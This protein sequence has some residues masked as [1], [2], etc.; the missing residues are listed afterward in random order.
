MWN[1]NIKK[2]PLYRVIQVN[3]V[4]WEQS[5]QRWVPSLLLYFVKDSIENTEV[6]FE[7]IQYSARAQAFALF[8]FFIQQ[9]SPSYLP[10]YLSNLLLSYCSSSSSPRPAN[11]QQ[12][13]GT[14]SPGL[15]I[16][17]FCVSKAWLCSLGTKQT[18]T[19][20]DSLDLRKGNFCFLLQN[21]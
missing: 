3:S 7:N 11:M 10:S 4:F 16:W 14:R 2:F 6:R 18:E 12:V 20:T 15:G 17:T 19:W 21:T 13:P 9:S 1:E 5:A 8:L